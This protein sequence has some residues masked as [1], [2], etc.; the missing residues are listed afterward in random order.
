MTLE[1]LGGPRRRLLA[2]TGLN[3]VS[4]LP[5]FALLDSDSRFPSFARPLGWSCCRST[6]QLPT[7]EFA[8][9]T[10]SLVHKQRALSEATFWD[11]GRPSKKKQNL[12]RS[13]G[14]IRSSEAQIRGSLAGVRPAGRGAGGFGPGRGWQERSRGHTP[15]QP[16][17]ASPPRPTHPMPASSSF[18]APFPRS[19]QG[20]YPFLSGSTQSGSICLQL[21]FLAATSC[22]FSLLLHPRWHSQSKHSFHEVHSS[23]PTRDPSSSSVTPPTLLPL[24]RLRSSGPASL[25][26]RP[27]AINHHPVPAA[28]TGKAEGKTLET[29]PIATP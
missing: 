11:P 22:P 1:P 28:D 19:F 26:S 10:R 20:V 16:R 5:V 7:Q 6:D 23:P 21:S 24:H 17:P 12:Q 8:R 4:I 9:K 3:C 13:P 2:G 18:P 27:R 29:P 14:R 25:S 15:P